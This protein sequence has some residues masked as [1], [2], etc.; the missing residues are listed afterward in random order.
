M[1]KILKPPSPLQDGFSVFL[2]GSIELG[3]AENWQ[4]FLEEKLSGI[5]I[6]ILNP[7]RDDWDAS[8]LQRKTNPKFREQVEWEL[9]AMEQ[10]N[11]IAMY[12]EPN[13]KS[14]VSLLEL[15]LFARS[16]KMVVCCPEGFW[17]KGNVDIVCEKYAVRQ[18][19][20]LNDL[21]EYI[22]RIAGDGGIPPC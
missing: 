7:R 1:A 18:V 12:F 10:A 19:E 2:A 20:A 15:G 5:D 4:T 11:I 3:S 14:P 17:R 21:A 22:L 9:T 16:G 8:W 13:T 6:L